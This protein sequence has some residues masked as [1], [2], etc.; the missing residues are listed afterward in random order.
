MDQ[1]VTPTRQRLSL[2]RVFNWS[3]AIWMVIL[4]ANTIRTADGLPLSVLLPVFVMS[5]VIYLLIALVCAALVVGVA[6]AIGR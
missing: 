2:Q 6:R 3:A 5:V 4:V 1:Q